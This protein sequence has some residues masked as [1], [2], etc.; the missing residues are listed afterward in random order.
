MKLFLIEIN[1]T[2]MAKV[3]IDNYTV[4]ASYESSEPEIGAKYRLISDIKKR[5]S[6]DYRHHMEDVTKLERE[7]E[8]LQDRSKDD[9]F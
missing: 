1:E 8:L 4:M 5:A 9:G 6:N 2:A 3:S 7:I